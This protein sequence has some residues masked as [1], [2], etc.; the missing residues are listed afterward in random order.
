IDIGAPVFELEDKSAWERINACCR[1][2]KV[3]P[4]ILTINCDVLWR[5]PLRTGELFN[6]SL[7]KRAVDA[8]VYLKTY[9][10][11]LVV[12]QI[13]AGQNKEGSF[14]ALV[15]SL[16]KVADYC[17]DQDVDVMVEV[18]VRGPITTLDEAVR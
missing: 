13:P 6:L 1:D 4:C 9:R 7:L 8:A 10:L 12:N 15:N 5:P 18:H 11:G 14:S 16:N 2:Y 17:R 3:K